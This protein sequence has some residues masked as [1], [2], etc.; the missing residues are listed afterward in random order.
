MLLR[1]CVAHYLPLHILQA[2]MC[3][4]HLLT[5]SPV[6][7]TQVASNSPTQRFCSCPCLLCV[8]L[9]EKF[10]GVYSQE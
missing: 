7:D 10:Y 1:V 3:P 4:P 8:D 9:R 5:Y 2:G 6:K